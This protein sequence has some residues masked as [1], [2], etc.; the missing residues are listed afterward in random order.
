VGNHDGLVFVLTTNFKDQLDDALIR[1][2]R[3]D[4]RVH[5]DY[6]TPEQM[7]K[8][9]D[10]FYPPKAAASASSDGSANFAVEADKPEVDPEVAALEAQLAALKKAKAVKAAVSA[11]GE[12]ADVVPNGAAFRDALLV[13]LGSHRVSAAQLQSFFVMHRKCA[14]AE[15]L[16]DVGSIVKA[17]EKRKDEEATNEAQKDPAE[18]DEKTKTGTTEAVQGENLKTA[19][20]EARTVHVHIHSSDE[21]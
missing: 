10:N 12:A 13:S 7:E 16:A 5:F 2:G 8:L 4:M 15:A 19:S 14:A 11:G 20:V 17:I 21:R 9:F 3:V 6:C 1:D 18:A